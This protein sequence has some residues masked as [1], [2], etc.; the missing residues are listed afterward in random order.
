MKSQRKNYSRKNKKTKKNS[1]RKSRSK[2]MRGGAPEYESVNN[3]EEVFKLLNAGGG[4]YDSFQIKKPHLITGVLHNEYQGKNIPKDKIKLL[5][6]KDGIVSTT[7]Y[8]FKNV[9]D[10]NALFNNP[11]IFDLETLFNKSWMFM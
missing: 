1:K 3:V 4:P 7:Y 10:A 2:K 5:V 9:E 8:D 11:E 6:N